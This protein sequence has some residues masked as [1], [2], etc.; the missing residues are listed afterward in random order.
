[1]TV[2]FDRVWPKLRRMEKGTL[3]T[4]IRHERTY[5]YWKS[6]E[7]KYEEIAIRGA[8][9]GSVRIH[10][11]ELRRFDSLGIRLLRLDT[12][13]TWGIDQIV[14]MF[15]RYY[16]GFTAQDKI[17]LIWMEVQ[18]VDRTYGDKHEVD[19]SN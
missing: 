8:R 7:G 5:R 4:T 3:I 16:P 14:A 1:M 17:T 13:P 9:W 15:K 18:T 6:R 2:K 19:K 10:G 12:R 11:V